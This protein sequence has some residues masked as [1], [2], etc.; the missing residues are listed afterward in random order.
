MKPCIVPCLLLVLLLAVG[1]CEVQ[2][3]EPPQGRSTGQKVHIEKIAG[4]FT[5]S[6]NG[7]PFSIHGA[8]G[9]PRYIRE[10]ARAGGNCLRVYDTLNLA[11]VLDTAHYY[12]IAIIADLPLPKSQHLSFY[13]DQA[14]V[15]GQMNAYRSFVD[16]HKDHPALLMWMLGNELDFPY[17]PNYTPF[18]R[19]YND[20]LA[21]IKQVDGQHPVA[22]ALTN[23]QRRTI[24]N[25]RLKIPDLDVLGINTFGLLKDLEQDMADFAWMWK[26][27]YFVS[28]WSING[29]WEVPKT[30]WGASIEDAGWKKKEELL[31]RFHQEMPVKDPRFL[32]S[33]LFYWGQKQELTATWF[34][35][36]TAGGQPTPLYE[37]Y[38][39]LNK[40][41]LPYL[42][43]P[44]VA[45]MLVDGA[46]AAGHI[47]LNPG[48]AY[49]ANIV[50]GIAPDT[51][52]RADWSLRSEDWYNLELDTLV[53]VVSYDHLLNALD[54]MSIQFSAPAREG[55]YRLFA[56]LSYP[57]S[58]ATTL[59]TPIYV[60][61]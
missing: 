9:D 26:G 32:G 17:K 20:L 61:E 11:Q 55:P 58:I 49:T 23:F 53:P 46:G 1:A 13:R 36:F 33:C 52:V 8:S 51:N 44:Q 10:L 14:K 16:R 19:A 7:Q 25:I 2:V 57:G 47:M 50:F 3:T 35:T 31:S 42:P 40:D 29:Y 21:M 59:N 38:A 41:T 37:A 30:A 54:T 27:P 60:I 4:H 48:Q 28:E 12:G 5:L 45:Y 39:L 43:A 18:Y 56:T 24:T 22:T 6:R 34:N 15:K